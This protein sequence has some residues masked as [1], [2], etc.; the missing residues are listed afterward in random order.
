MFLLDSFFISAPASPGPL[1]VVAK[2]AEKTVLRTL[3]T[4]GNIGAV[5][6]NYM[7]NKAAAQS[8][9]ADPS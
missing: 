7:L 1:L 6:Y 3:N 8:A 2:T 9:G 4:I 5:K